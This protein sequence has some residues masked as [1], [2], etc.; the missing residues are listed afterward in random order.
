MGGRRLIL[1]ELWRGREGGGGGGGQIERAKEGEEK[2]KMEREKEMPCDQGHHVTLLV[3]RRDVAREEG[4][5][6]TAD[7]DM[8]VAATA[9]AAVRKQY[10]CIQ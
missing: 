7:Q 4:S 1:E 2:R 3:G 8:S 5:G 6:G 10:T 9:A